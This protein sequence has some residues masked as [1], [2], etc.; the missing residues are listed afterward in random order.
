MTATTIHPLTERCD[1]GDW[2]DYHQAEVRTDAAAM[3]GEYWT[4]TKDLH[5]VL[6]G[7]RLEAAV[8]DHWRSTPATADVPACI[9]VRRGYPWDGASG[10]AIDDPQAIVASLV[11]DIICTPMVLRHRGR[12]RT[13]YACPSYMDRHALY[14]DILRAQ[15]AAW[16]RAWYSWAALVAANWVL[17]LRSE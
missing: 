1:P 4:T 7:V 12:T 14:R 3:V 6:P 2:S 15:G 10:P 16:G 17:M 5:I 11:H 8:C 9:D 13:F